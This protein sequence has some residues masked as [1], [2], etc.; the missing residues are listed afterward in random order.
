MQKNTRRK[1]EIMRP[2]S[3]GDDCCQK[4]ELFV[5]PITCLSCGIHMVT[6]RMAFAAST[7][8]IQ[9]N[10]GYL[11]LFVIPGTAYLL[12]LVCMHLLV[13]KLEAGNMEEFNS[14]S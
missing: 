10:F 4:N 2:V 13:P 9:V 8:L 12:A 1:A 3:S 6:T 5:T 7:G 14:V 11:P